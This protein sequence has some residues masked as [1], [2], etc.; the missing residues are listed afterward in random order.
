[1]NQLAEDDSLENFQQAMDE[2]LYNVGQDT[3]EM[4][5]EID[6]LTAKLT[7]LEGDYHVN[8]K[9]HQTGSVPKVPTTKGLPIGGQQGLDMVVPRGFPN[10]TFPIRATSGEHVQITPRG[11]D[12]QSDM[13]HLTVNIN[14]PQINSEIDIDNMARQVAE[15]I[16]EKGK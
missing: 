12:K 4:E 14:N 1:L 2:T 6:D 7:E 9:I 16:Q 13:Q 5:V 8:I 15:A 3:D 11:K 10:D